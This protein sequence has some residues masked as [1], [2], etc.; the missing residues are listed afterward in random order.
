MSKKVKILDK[1]FELSIPSSTIQEAVSKI[2]KQLNND[3]KEAKKEIVFIGIL[4]GSFMFASDLFKQIT[5]PC[6]ITFFKIS[7]LPG[8]IVHRCC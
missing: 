3:L 6:K 4:N 7:L 8:D 1:E 5:L 2:A